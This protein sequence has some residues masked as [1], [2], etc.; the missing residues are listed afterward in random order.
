MN[1]QSLTMTNSYAAGNE[2]G[3][4]QGCDYIMHKLE[5]AVESNKDAW[6]IG[7]TLMRF[8]YEY[9]GI[10]SGQYKYFPENQK[11]ESE[12]ERKS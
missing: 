2:E 6:A 1:K 11:K 4:Y 5:K 10:W 7:V 8:C 3:F 12:N 9:R